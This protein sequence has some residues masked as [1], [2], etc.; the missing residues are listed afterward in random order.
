MDDHPSRSAPGPVLGGPLPVVRLEIQAM[1]ER[2]L[3]A[4][5]DRRGELEAQI[6][7]AVEEQIAAFD[8]AEEVRRH[9]VPAL[10]KHTQWAVETAVGRAVAAAMAEPAV[11]ERLRALVVTAFT[12]ALMGPEA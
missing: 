9:L 5:A 7:Q 10:R 6:R 1:T 4:V 12:G 3:M 11:T 8:V 2:I